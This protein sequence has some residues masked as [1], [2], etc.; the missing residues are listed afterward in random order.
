MAIPLL[1]GAAIGGVVGG[2]GSLLSGGPKD[3]LR[4]ESRQFFNENIQ[5]FGGAGQ[6]A[7]TGFDPST[8]QFGMPSGPFAGPLA[9]EFGP[10]SIARFADPNIAA[11]EEMLGT[12]RDR[13]LLMARRDAQGAAAMTGSGRGSRAGVALGER[14]AGV[15][16]A[17]FES[18]LAGRM[19]FNE[20][21][22]RTALGAQG[23]RNEALGANQAL[24]RFGAG[25]EAGNFG[26]GSHPSQFLTAEAA[27]GEKKPSLVSG[28]I[29]GAISGAGMVGG[30]GAGSV[31][32]AGQIQGITG[33][34][35]TVDP[36]QIPGNVQLPTSIGGPG[37]GQNSFGMRQP[38]PGFRFGG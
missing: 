27:T 29:G 19:G 31:M 32:N 36:F 4:P 6:Q 3:P 9:E 37:F 7:I 2:I 25:M 20:Q 21:A 38:P 11:F 5:Q 10:E 34:Q 12:Q 33:P 24:R 1:A 28:I 22:S 16:R 13:S 35:R 30:G 8:G 26:F 17:F 15:D 23:F 18:L 14:Q